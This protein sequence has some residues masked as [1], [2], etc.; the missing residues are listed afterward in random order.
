MKKEVIMSVIFVVG[1]IVA[2]LVGY[3]LPHNF[4]KLES[5]PLIKKIGFVKIVG[6]N[7]AID[8]WNI[9]AGQ[10]DCM[11]LITIMNMNS[12]TGITQVTLNPSNIM[13]DTKM[14]C[15]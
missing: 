7:H 2:L 10:Q 12:L 1:L 8:I 15:K 14:D 4:L 13:F 6:T 9:K 11:L 5:D 3:I